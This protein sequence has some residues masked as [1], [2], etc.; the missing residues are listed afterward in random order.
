[1][2][3]ADASQ[4]SPAAFKEVVIVGANDIGNM[5]VPG[6]AGVYVVGTGT[7]GVAQAF[8]TLGAVYFVIMMCAAFGY[9]VPADRAGSQ[10]AGNRPRRI[11]STR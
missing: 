10:K 7:V 3:Q 8:F 9:R 4:K 5:L 1:M 11:R 2:N 6:D